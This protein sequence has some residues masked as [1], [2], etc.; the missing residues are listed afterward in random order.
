MDNL[1]SPDLQNYL[2]EVTSPEEPLLSHLRQETKT[3]FGMENMITGPVAGKFLQFL[4]A[5]SG[6]K[7]CLE[8]GTFTGYSALNIAKALPMDGK[9]ITC[10]IDATYAKFAQSYFN[11]SPHGQ[12]IEIKQGNSITIIPTLNI[13]FDFIFIDADKANYPHYYEMLLPKLRTHGL[14]VIDNA[15]WKGEVINPQDKRTQAIDALN[16]KARQDE[17]V[18]TVMLSVRDGML[19]IRKL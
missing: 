19:L 18:E 4:V 7:N 1:F 2:I 11:K 13:T 14:M 10:E 8:L 5:L 16:K 17:T 9:L 12:K 6:A 15:L 3:T